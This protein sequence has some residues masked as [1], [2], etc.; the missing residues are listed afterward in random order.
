MGYG[1]VLNCMRGFLSFYIG[2]STRTRGVV[3]RS[4]HAYT[5]ATCTFCTE[6][7]EIHKILQFQ[8]IVLG[9]FHC[10][11]QRQLYTYMH[12]HKN[13]HTCTCAVGGTDGLYKS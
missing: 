11:Y 4:T 12:T 2:R 7:S 9:I 6:C 1:V 5:L 10:L 3:C 8:A 13:T